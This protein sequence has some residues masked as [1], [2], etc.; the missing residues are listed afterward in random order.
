MVYAKKS[1]FV[2]LQYQKESNQEIMQHKCLAQY[3]FS[4][5]EASNLLISRLYA[6]WKSSNFLF[7]TI[8]SLIMCFSCVNSTKNIQLR[9]VYDVCYCKFVCS[10]VWMCRCEFLQTGIIIPMYRC[11]QYSRLGVFK[12]RV[13]KHRSTL[14]DRISVVQWKQ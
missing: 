5:F 14:F 13:Q 4:R 2:I 11:T 6:L 10:S 1:F 3:I 8:Y 7:R 12:K 9:Y